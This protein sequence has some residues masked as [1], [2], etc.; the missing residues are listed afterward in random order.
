[1][2]LGNR[3]Q[4][5]RLRWQT[6]S[7]QGR[8]PGLEYTGINLK[9][10]K[11][12]GFPTQRRQGA[13][14]DCERQLSFTPYSQDSVGPRA[15]WT[16]TNVPARPAGMAPSVWTSPMAMSVAVRRVRGDRETVARTTRWAGGLV[17]VKDQ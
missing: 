3:T 1:M 12:G 7:P 6:L 4:V 17:G 9:Q 15:S 16:W 5:V 11:G 14:F 8:L 2:G 10:N 13:C